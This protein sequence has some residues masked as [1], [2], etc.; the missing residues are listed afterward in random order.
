MSDGERYG[1][2]GRLKPRGTS[3]MKDPYGRCGA[4]SPEVLRLSGMVAR[5][6]TIRCGLP[7]GHT[8]P[9]KGILPEHLRTDP[10][11][12]VWVWER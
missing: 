12:D 7:A 9:H 6:E 11:Q 10:K 5:P 2:R 8:E 4:E 1:G 3:L